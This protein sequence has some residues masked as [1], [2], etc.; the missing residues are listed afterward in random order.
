MGCDAR[1]CSSSRTSSCPAGAPAAPAASVSRIVVV[2][3]ARIVRGVSSVAM[4]RSGPAWHGSTIAR[5]PRGNAAST[6][7]S[8]SSPSVMTTTGCPVPAARSA[9]PRSRD[10]W[11]VGSVRESS[12]RVESPK[13]S[14]VPLPARDAE[15]SAEPQR[16]QVAP[17][18]V[19]LSDA[20]RAISG[21]SGLLRPP[22]APSTI[23][24]TIA[25]TAARSSAS[26]ATAGR[27]AYLPYCRA[28]AARPTSDAKSQSAIRSFAYPR[29]DEGETPR[30]RAAIEAERR[31]T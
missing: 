8:S 9:T 17:P 21:A 1:S 19:Q 11:S 29:P 18:R 24:S 15:S 31:A 5:E 14:Q 16:P 20:S 28:A 6:S 13:R 30:D 12:A 10:A 27:R 22:G 26:G 23:A 4:A 7:A 25:T 3:P 2:S